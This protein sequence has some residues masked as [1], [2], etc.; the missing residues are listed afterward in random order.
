MGLIFDKDVKMKEHIKECIKDDFARQ[1]TRSAQGN[2][3]HRRES[4]HEAV[5]GW[6]EYREQAKAIRNDVLEHLDYYL[7]QFIKKTT[8]NGNIVHFAED[9]KE[10]QRLLLEIC[11]SKNAKSVVKSKSMVSEEIDCNKTL[12][13]AGIEVNETD[14]GEYMIQLDDWNHPSHLLMP[15]MHMSI[16]DTYVLFQKYGYKGAMEAHEM[17]NFARESLRQKFL[18]A[19]VGITGCNFAIVSTGSTSIIT[20]EGNGR[21]VTSMPETQIVLM[22]MERLLPNMQ[23]FDAMMQIFVRHAVGTSIS[24]Y[25]SF[26]NTPRSDEAQDGPKEVHIIIIDNGRSRILGSKY[27]EML[28][29]I[30]CG[31]CQNVCPVFR[32]ITGHGYGSCYQGPMGIVYTPL[33]NG[34][35]EYTKDM[36]YACTLCGRCA[37]TCPVKIP[38]HE[39]ILSERQDIVEHT[40]L[41]APLERSVFT[42]AGTGLGFKPIFSAGVKAAKPG[43]KVLA[44]LTGEKTHLGQ[45]AQLPVVKNWTDSRNMPLLRTGEFREWFAK[46]QKEGK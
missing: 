14:L 44:Q 42:A 6:E 16:E 10:A 17:T 34:F 20:N 36:P 31:T 5:E 4:M 39:L 25:M 1:A 8:E 2:F 26:S 28:R 7:D 22:G 27:R 15:G 30:R 33:L 41:V 40:D 35:D 24:S 13:D 23:A 37:E 32:H 29:C 3:N 12:L 19:D 18:K 9:D 38:L 21:M 11:H 43:M 45:K 46:H